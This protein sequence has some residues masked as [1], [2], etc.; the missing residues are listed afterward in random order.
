M[1]MHIRKM[2]KNYQ[3]QDNLMSNMI[4]QNKAKMQ[5]LEIV[6]EVSFMDLKIYQGLEIIIQLKRH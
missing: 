6:K 3:D 1:A 4:G 2:R 5:V